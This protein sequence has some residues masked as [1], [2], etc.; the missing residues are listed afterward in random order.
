[1][2]AR[3]FTFW[4]RIMTIIPILLSACSS[5][6]A[7]P[8]PEPQP[9]S[10]EQTPPEAAEEGQT[11]TIVT[12]E[13]AQNPAEEKNQY[14]IHTR[15]TDFHLLNESTGIAWGLTNNA[16]RL[17]LTEDYGVTWVDISPSENV[18]FTDKLE[19]GRDIVFPDKDHGWI[20]RNQRGGAGTVLLNTDDGGDTWSISSLPERGSVMAVAFASARLGWIMSSE[21]SF[22]YAQDKTLFQTDDNG[23]SWD[24]VMQNSDYPSAN[25]P[26]TVMPQSGRV[27]G[28]DFSNANVGLATVKDTHLSRL[29]ITRD[30]GQKWSSSAQV[31]N[32]TSLNRCEDITP[33]KPKFLGNRTDAYIPVTCYTEDRTSYFG[34]F[35][36]DSGKSW[37]LVPFERIGDM[38]NG[39]IQ[40]VFRRLYD[41]WKMANGIVYH[42]TDMGKNWKPFPR[43]KLLTQNLGNYPRV[44][45]LQFFS[46]KV[47]WLLIETHDQKRS[48]LMKSTDGGVTWQGI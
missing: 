16:L 42:T 24:K 45:K 48:R 33:G 41:G 23:R 28:M 8:Q 19:Y 26:S 11:I 38:E 29:Y 47:G 12:P 40:P 1:M 46:S 39:S 30:G 34:Y 18:K 43:D 15:L 9:Q 44:V 10:L 3:G 22:G 6:Q 20:I 27:I 36:A 4:I 35:T 13:T 7:Q 25:I 21:K 2:K 5:E 14:Q 32:S 17:Y 37:N 31:F